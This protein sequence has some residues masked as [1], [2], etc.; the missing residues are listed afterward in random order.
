[1]SVD[2]ESIDPSELPDRLVPLEP[3][4]D[5]VDVRADRLSVDSRENAPD[6]VSAG[7]GPSHPP[8]PESGPALLLQGVERAQAREHH[9]HH[10]AKH[11]GCG[12]KGLAAAIAHP[13]DEPVKLIDL[14]GVAQE[15][16]EH[17]YPFFFNLS[18]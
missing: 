3:G 15:A 9:Q 14:V 2:D 12:D 18:Q 1:M 13:A 8:P 4:V 17:R 7:K 6:G 5:V 11:G 10:A 16:T